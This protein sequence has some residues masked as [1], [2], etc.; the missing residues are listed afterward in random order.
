MMC[1]LDFVKM[2][3]DRMFFNHENGRCT[4]EVGT[5]FRFQNEDELDGYVY[6]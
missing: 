4:D 1:S 2:E 6:I 3:F 5:A